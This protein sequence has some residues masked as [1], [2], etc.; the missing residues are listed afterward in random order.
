MAVCLILPGA[1]PPSW[2]DSY[3]GQHWTRRRETVALLRQEV[4]A[5]IDPDK[6]KIFDQPVH[7][8]I[9]VFFRDIND[10]PVDVDNISSKLYIDALKGWYI[11]DDDWSCVSGVTSLVRFD[12]EN[13]RIEI[14]IR[15]S[16]IR[17]YPL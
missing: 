1:R 2:N 5:A 14:E 11:E 16:S 3:A 13:P 8:T 17:D 10:K 12:N 7:I 6:A 4:R 9:T 15:Q